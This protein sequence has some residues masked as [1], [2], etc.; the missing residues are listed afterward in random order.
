LIQ[1]NGPRTRRPAVTSRRGGPQS[2]AGAITPVAEARLRPRDFLRPGGV[3]VAGQTPRAAPA[4]ARRWDA[5][6]AGQAA[7]A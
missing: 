4:K 6:T 5:Q 2:P 3:L 1:I 7:A